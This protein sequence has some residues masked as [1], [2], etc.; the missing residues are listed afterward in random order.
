VRY[1]EGFQKSKAV[2]S[3]LREAGNTAY[4]AGDVSNALRGYNLALSFAPNETEELSLVY[5]NRAAVFLQLEMPNEALRDVEEALKFSGHC[6]KVQER[7]QE[8]KVKCQRLLQKGQKEGGKKEDED[9]FKNLFASEDQEEGREFCEKKLLQVNNNQS[10]QS[11]GGG[12]NNGGVL[13]GAADFV[14]VVYSPECGRRLVVTQDVPA[15]NK[16][17]FR[18]L[19]EIIKCE[20]IVL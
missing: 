5:G 6:E 18:K 19:K 4:K 16:C 1:F 10:S 8:R 17:H 14:K 9:V 3:A 20:Y 12:S 2:S 11:A 13:K 7:L 15:G